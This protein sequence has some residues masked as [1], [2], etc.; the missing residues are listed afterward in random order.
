MYIQ[1]IRVRVYGRMQRTYYSICLL[2]KKIFKS[3][4]SLN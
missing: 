2:E 4:T 3:G 1:P